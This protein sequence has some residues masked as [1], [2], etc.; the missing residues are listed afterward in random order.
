[1]SRL[2]RALALGFLVAAL[3]LVAFATES[4]AADASSRALPTAGDTMTV[5]IVAVL[6]VLALFLIASLGYLYRRERH[7]EWDFQRPDATQHDGG[8]H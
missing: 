8:H 1:M 6:A 5:G 7:L 2:V 4:T 3:P